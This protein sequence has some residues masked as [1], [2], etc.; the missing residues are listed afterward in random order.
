MK[1]PIYLSL[2]L[3]PLSSCSLFQQDNTS[4]LGIENLEEQEDELLIKAMAGDASALD[5]LGFYYYVSS[6]QKSSD[7]TPFQLMNQ[8]QLGT[9]LLELAAEKGS[10]QSA[11][12]L[13]VH[14]KPRLKQSQPNINILAYWDI[15]TGDEKKYLHYVNQL[16]KSKSKYDQAV[17]YAELGD[18]NLAKKPQLAFS[19]FKKS[20]QAS[21]AEGT[22]LTS[23]GHLG[24]AKC[25]ID[26]T[27]CKKNLDKAEQIAKEL[28]DI[29]NAHFQAQGCY[30]MSK[31]HADDP[32]LSEHWRNKRHDLLSKLGEE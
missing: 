2:L 32:K 17:G 4:K 22:P 9:Q 25:Y 14:F 18:W 10:M 16:V 26:G 29:D 3:L 28:L 23:L 7:K 13:I 12:R 15:P 6:F 24:L 27:G 20:Y 11:H 19:Y 21:K 1:T 8:R 31:L 30:I 5:S